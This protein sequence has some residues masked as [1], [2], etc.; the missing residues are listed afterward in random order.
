MGL[1]N[2]LL[3]LTHE[4]VGTALVD[5]L[6]KVNISLDDASAVGDRL[7]ADYPPLAKAVSVIEAFYVADEE[8]DR[9]GAELIG[10]GALLAFG[11][12]KEVGE[13]QEISHLSE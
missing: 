7:Y 5:L 12:L 9:E 8:L 3:Q 11:V 2:E 13:N 1:R 10:Y 4:E 6:V